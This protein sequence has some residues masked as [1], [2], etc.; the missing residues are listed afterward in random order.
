[1]R[2][3][4]ALLAAVALLALSVGTGGCGL[5]DSLTP[6]GVGTRDYSSAGDNV[7]G[8]WFGTTDSGGAVSFQVASETVSVPKFLDTVA[9]CTR[10]FTSEAD[11]APVVDGRFTIQ[12]LYDQGR[13]VASGTFTSDG[14]C[15]GTF[16]FE[17]LGASACPSNGTG[18]FVAVKVF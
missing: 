15:S 9:D 16:F 10:D 17:A 8:T 7:N 4:G 5:I 18:T 13:F 14:T 2:K 6:F 11:T 12:I 1:M 3:A